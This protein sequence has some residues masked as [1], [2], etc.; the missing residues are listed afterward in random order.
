MS[1]VSKW[2]EDKRT[3]A[4]KKADN[5]RRA[6]DYIRRG[7]LSQFDELIKVNAFNVNADCKDEYSNTLLHIAVS[8]KKYNIVEY[9]IQIGA[10]IIKSNIFT[11]TPWDIAVRNQDTKMIRILLN[12]NEL[13]TNINNLIRENT[14]LRNESVSKLKRKCGDCENKDREIKRIKTERSD[15][16]TK[17][18]GDVKKL[19]VDNTD[20]R[21]TIESL[22]TSFQK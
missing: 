12:I 15:C 17:L 19:Q 16:E 5:E 21:T 10:D 6:R 20:L 7:K 13:N 9:L 14:E 11:E 1:F 4:E 18:L 8:S 22:R 3:V 2:F